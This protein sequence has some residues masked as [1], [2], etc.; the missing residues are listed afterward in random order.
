MNFSNSLHGRREIFSML[1]F[2][3][4]F[5]GIALILAE[6]KGK[7]TEGMGKRENE[8]EFREKGKGRAP[9]LN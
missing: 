9:N 4:L 3:M 5:F 8:I 6:K 7:K 1:V 2:F